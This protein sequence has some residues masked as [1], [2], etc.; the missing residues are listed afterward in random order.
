M[1]ETR[2]RDM[3]AV[4]SA[5][6]DVEHYLEAYE[7]AQV[8]DGDA[9]LARFLPPADD[10]HYLR[11]LR[12]L[13]CL[14]LEYSWK[15][16]RP[17]RMQA[18]ADAYPRLSDDPESL[19]ALA[20]EEYRLRLQGGERPTRA[21]YEQRYGVSTTGWPDGVSTDRVQPAKPTLSMDPADRRA[22]G[23]HAPDKAAD[24]EHAARAFQ[25]F[26]QRTRGG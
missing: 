10:A 17:K 1:P 15:R 2:K 8:R 3:N 13:A 11:V 20:F 9:E 26:L 7:A 23:P 6:K 21:E 4:G 16:G 12:E 25:S 18:F 19:Q 5:W 24:L 14:E 22:A